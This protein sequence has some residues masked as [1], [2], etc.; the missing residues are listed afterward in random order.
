[1]AL[2]S[3]SGDRQARTMRR[4][5]FHAVLQQ[6]VRDPPPNDGGGRWEEA[7]TFRMVSSRLELIALPSKNMRTRVFLW[8]ELCF[9]EW[10]QK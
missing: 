4:E 10:S 8:C 7:C 3:I 2:F 9:N 1:M 5:V 6:E